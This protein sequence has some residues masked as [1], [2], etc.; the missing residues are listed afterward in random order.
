MSLKC[1][2]CNKVVEV[3]Q[4]HKLINGDVYCEECLKLI[5]EN[6]HVGI[7]I[8][9]FFLIN[10]VKVIITILLY[11]SMFLYNLIFF[12]PFFVDT[13]ASVFE[14]FVQIAYILNFPVL[15]VADEIKTNNLFFQFVINIAGFLSVLLWNY[16]ISCEVYHLYNNIQSKKK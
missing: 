13:S 9:K 14:M 12:K 11:V 3:W 4:S 8:K 7:R 10:K 5:E 15:Y 6:K 1:V 2:K 16:L